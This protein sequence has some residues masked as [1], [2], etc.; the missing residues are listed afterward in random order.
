M[1]GGGQGRRVRGAEVGVRGMGRGQICKCGYNMCEMSRRGRKS[2]LRGE[3]RMQVHMHIHRVA[4][5]AGP[6]RVPHLQGLCQSH[7]A[8]ESD[9]SI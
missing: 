6:C 2:R 5:R 7:D 4:T 9:L 8:A 1:A 3:T